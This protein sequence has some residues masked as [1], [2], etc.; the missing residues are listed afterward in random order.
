MSDNEK[1]L[2]HLRFAS[3][4]LKSEGR[5]GSSQAVTQAVELI[6][7]LQAAV[8]K[9]VP[10]GD[11]PDEEGKYFVTGPTGFGTAFFHGDGWYGYGN[12]THWMECPPQ[13]PTEPSNVD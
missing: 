8:P 2:D 6:T 7:R 4:W 5:L 12:D 1:L 13:P 11:Y 10:I 3:R 9:W